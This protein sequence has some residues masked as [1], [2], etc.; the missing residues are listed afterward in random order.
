M[1]LEDILGKIKADAEAEAAKIAAAAGAE[2]A[3]LLEAAAA[4]AAQATESLRL[5]GQAAAEDARRRELATAGVEARRVVLS[6]KQEVL[7][8]V[9]DRA[10]HQLA[11]MPDGEYRQL[12]AAIADRAAVTGDE[13]VVV[14]VRDRARLGDDWLKLANERLTSRGLPG[15]LT[16][17]SSTR[18]LRGGLILLAPDADFNC[19]FERTLSSVRDNLEPAVAV[20]LF[21]PAAAQGAGR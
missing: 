3:R 5:A 7:E 16:Y 8:S 11:E 19:S 1:A 17:A 21:E 20:L 14:S 2:R 10:L 13:R 9:F 4:R 6:A 15:R 12:L 18:P